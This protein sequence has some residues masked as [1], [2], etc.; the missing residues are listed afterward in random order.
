MPGKITGLGPVNVEKPVVGRLTLLR[1]AARPV[2]AGQ[3]RERAT[4]DDYEPSYAKV[5]LICS[6]DGECIR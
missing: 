3:G 2:R 6:T 5:V 1:A 4:T